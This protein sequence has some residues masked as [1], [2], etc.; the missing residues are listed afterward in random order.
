MAGRHGGTVQGRR[1]LRG[2]LASPGKVVGVGASRW[3]GVTARQDL[4]T[5]GAIRRRWRSRWARRGGGLQRAGAA[6]GGPGAGALPLGA[7]A[8]R[9]ARAGGGVL[10][11]GSTRARCSGPA[12]RKV[13][14]TVP[15]RPEP[16]RS[17][18]PPRPP[19]GKGCAS[20]LRKNRPQATLASGRSE[21][22]LKVSAPGGMSD[23]PVSP[24][25]MRGASGRRWR[26]GASWHG[27]GAGRPG[28]VALP[29]VAAARL[30]TWLGACPGCPGGG[31][32]LPRQGAGLRR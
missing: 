12:R 18:A 8:A 24:G 4:A 26:R 28:A 31:L 30:A 13:G 3:P 22:R 15:L 21:A 20:G 32:S 2:S 5:R 27:R 17:V 14:G 19:S 16:T 7:A 29:L 10:Q 23:T 9:L 11:G 25:G 1:A 6:A